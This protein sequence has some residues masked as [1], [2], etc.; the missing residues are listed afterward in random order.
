MLSA[1]KKQDCKRILKL[2]LLHFYVEYFLKQL[3]AFSEEAGERFHQDVKTLSKK[4]EYYYNGR[5]LLD[6]DEDTQTRK[7][8]R[9]NER[10]EELVS[11]SMA[12]DIGDQLNS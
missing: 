9:M 4:M 2:R 3:G 7:C 11:Q 12:M 5:Q 6:T 10:K 1:F 8:T